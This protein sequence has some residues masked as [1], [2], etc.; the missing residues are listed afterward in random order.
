MLGGTPT[1]PSKGKRNE[2]M[3]RVENNNFVG[4]TA[5]VKKEG[6]KVATRGVFGLKEKSYC[7]GADLREQK[8]GKA[9][10]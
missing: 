1:L 10:N 5:S 7:G 9:E 2:A 8:R 6:G 3:G 4:E